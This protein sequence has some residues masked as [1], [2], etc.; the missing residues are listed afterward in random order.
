[1]QHLKENLV[2]QF[3]VISFIIMFILATTLFIVLSDRI[4]ADA[5]N[6]LAEEAIGSASGR[7][8]SAITSSDLETPMQGERY[9]RF[10][11]F[12][13]ESIVSDRTA[14]VKVWAKD[15][16][17]IYSNDPAGVGEKFPTNENLLKALRGENP[18]EIKIPVDAEN[19]RERYLGTLMEV[20]T[21]IIFPGTTEPS[22][23]F[24]IYQYYEPTARRVGELRLWT[25]GAIGVGFVVLYGS[26]VYIVWGGWQT[27]RRQQAILAKTNEDLQEAIKAKEEMIANVSHEL[28]TPL[29][30]IIGYSELLTDGVIGTGLS[31]DLAHALQVILDRAQ[32]LARLVDALL[33]LQ[34]RAPEDLDWAPLNLEHLV[35]TTVLAW[36]EYARRKHI[37]LS[38][39]TDPGVPLIMGDARNLRKVLDQ[40]L[41]NAFKFTGEGGVVSL[42]VETHEAEAWISVSDTG[43]G[44]QKD[45]LVKVFEEFYQADD[46][47][48]RRYGGAGIGLALVRR[49]A[50]L[51]GGRVWA[52]SEGEGLGATIRLALPITSAQQA[53]RPLASTIGLRLSAR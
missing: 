35:A 29:T 8:L 25:F 2:I 38:L 11:Q 3:S 28:R 32:A 15:G 53:G 39:K 20:Y 42:G 10:H 36:Q 4:R 37:T 5:L 51:H 31:A 19:D 41:D 13:Q 12:V 23:V 6:A 22:G 33:S 49:I 44:I 21:P 34:A 17:V 16:T 7:L 43:I 24:E 48:N 26:L 30:Q 40:L 50:A 14:R 46:S 47:L 45:K 27:I 1:M 18:L 52:E 9:N